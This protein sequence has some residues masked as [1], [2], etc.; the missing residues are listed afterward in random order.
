M[1]TTR[2]VLEPTTVAG[3]Q[4]PLMMTLSAFASID[5][6]PLPPRLHSIHEQAILSDLGLALR[7][8]APNWSPVWVGLSSDHD[9]NMAYIAHNELVTNQYAVAIRGTDFDILA[10]TWDDAYVWETV[11]FPAGG[12]IAQGTAD[13]HNM[14]VAAVG[15]SGRTLVQELASRVGPDGQSST[16]FVTGHS[17]GGAL[18]TTVALYLQAALPKAVFQVYTF[19]APTA[20]L[21]DFASTYDRVFS[22]NGI[23]GNSSWRIY[24]AWDAIP[25][26]WQAGTLSTLPS[27]Y[28]APGPTPSDSDWL[29][30]EALQFLPAGQPYQQPT[31]N[32]CQLNDPDWQAA[33]KNAQ[34]GFGGEVAFQHDCNTYLT[35]LKA[36]NVA[37]LDNVSPNAL[38]RGAGA[39]LTLTGLGFSD[40]TTVSFSNG[41]I[42]VQPPVLNG[43]STLKVTVSV[44]ADA[45]QGPCDVIVTS[46]NGIRIPG[47]TTSFFVT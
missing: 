18:A 37:V 6:H 46:G 9:A 15:S 33:D 45:P 40:Q 12:T 10:N 42:A 38:S 35:L 5:E 2:S 31:V 20:G 25:Q 17:L 14:L 32:V 7:Q 36:G 47:G 21:T 28:P 4:A 26:A 39:T 22:G 8:A 29:A 13:A 1:K 41:G 34:A 3:P 11:A 16:I 44:A 43:P 23:G 24:N 30:L 27:W 19:A